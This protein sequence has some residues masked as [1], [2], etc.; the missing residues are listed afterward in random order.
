MNDADYDSESRITR[1][2]IVATIIVVCSVVYAFTIG[3][4]VLAIRAFLLFMVPLTMIWLP[5]VLIR[6]A[7]LDAKWKRQLVAPAS[8]FSVRM[9]AWVVIVGV[10]AAWI[11][12]SFTR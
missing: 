9:I 7:T 10:P 2:R 3:G 8:K 4:Y 6:I 11:I 12:S 1:E 5:D